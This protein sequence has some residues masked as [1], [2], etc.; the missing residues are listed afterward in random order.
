MFGTTDDLQKARRNAKRSRAFAACVS[1][2]SARTQCSDYRPCKRCAEFGKA[3]DCVDQNET[4]AKKAYRIETTNPIFCPLIS[5]NSNPDKSSFLSALQNSF[6]QERSSQ[7]PALQS[8]T[9]DF[10][11]Q[12]TSPDIKQSRQQQTAALHNPAQAL[13]GFHLPFPFPYPKRSSEQSSV[14]LTL[15]NGACYAETPGLNPVSSI[16]VRSFNDP[17]PT[18]QAED[19]LH[20]KDQHTVS[21]ISQPDAYNSRAQ[22]SHLSFALSTHQQAAALKRDPISF[23]HRNGLHLTCPLPPL[24]MASGPG[25]MSEPL[26]LSHGTITAMP[27]ST[28]HIPNPSI[29]LL[30]PQTRPHCSPSPA[31]FLAVGRLRLLLPIAASGSTPAQAMALPSVS[32]LC[33]WPSAAGSVGAAPAPDLEAIASA[34]LAQRSPLFEAGMWSGGRP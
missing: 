19:S 7:E 16:P 23:Q 11:V 2:K 6:V 5:Q 25:R 4:N 15:C 20:G 17:K 1:C 28:P 14:Q 34:C 9:N 18:L 27:S 26:A 30:T 29:N 31:D 12:T 24:S 32:S 33:Q 3:G 10:M 8:A 21:F 22:T 13:H